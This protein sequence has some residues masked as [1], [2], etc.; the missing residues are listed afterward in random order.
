MRRTTNLKKEIKVIN[1]E[2]FH[3]LECKDLIL[4]LVKFSSFEFDL[5]IQQNPNELFHRFFFCLFAVL[6]IEVGLYICWASALPSTIHPNSKVYYIKGKR[7]KI[8]SSL[9]EDK[10]K[11]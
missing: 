1:G 2:R 10:D 5:K 4:C 9:L 3:V 6:G 11:V 7:L 8:R